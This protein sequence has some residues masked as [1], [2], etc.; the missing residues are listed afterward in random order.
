MFRLVLFD[1]QGPGCGRGCGAGDARAGLEGS[2]RVRRAGPLGTWIYAIARNTCL[3][4]LRK[5][6]PMVSFDDP[7]SHEAQRGRGEHRNRTGE[8]PR[9]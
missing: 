5:R 6:R 9:A 4:E 2:A 7:D 1:P 3:M 8:R